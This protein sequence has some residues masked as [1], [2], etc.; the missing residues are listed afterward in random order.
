M[1]IGSEIE[2]S[3][4]DGQPGCSWNRDLGELLNAQIFRIDLEDRSTEKDIKRSLRIL[5]QGRPDQAAKP[6]EVFKVNDLEL[7]E[8]ENKIIGAR[9]NPINI[10][11]RPDFKAEDFGSARNWNGL[12]NHLFCFLIHDGEDS[13]PLPRVSSSRRKN[14]RPSNQV[15]VW[16][17]LQSMRTVERNHLFMGEQLFFARAQVDDANPSTGPAVSHEPRH[18]DMPAIWWARQVRGRLIAASN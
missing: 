16:Q 1:G 9:G 10:I 18:E 14:T 17:S 11:S 6:E 4:L 15:A 2:P 3:V 13:F 8:V 12:K 7:S 5:H